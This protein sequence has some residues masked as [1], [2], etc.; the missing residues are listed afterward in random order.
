[1]EFGP[2]KLYL[3][4]RAYVEFLQRL[5]A[6]SDRYTWDPD[7]TRTKIVITAMFPDKIDTHAKLPLVV[8]S[9]NGGSWRGMAISNVM[10]GNIFRPNQTPRLYA[11]I[12]M[13]SATIYVFATTEAECSLLSW[14]IFKALPVFRH[15]LHRA[16]GVGVVN[17]RV[18][19][20]RPRDAAG[21]FS[22]APNTVWVAAI[23]SPF[24]VHEET[25]VTEEPQVKNMYSDTEIKTEQ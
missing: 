19:I 13:A 12:V 25:F 3:V 5:F 20:G 11:D 15:E 24:D 9:T 4:G 21:V 1:M 8:V 7:I 23:Y 18:S 6:S 16:L 22:V 10:Y 14:I 2:D 17:H